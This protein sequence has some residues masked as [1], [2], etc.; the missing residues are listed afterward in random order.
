MSEQV[1]ERP[2]PRGGGFSLSKRY[3][4]LP[5]WAWGLLGGAAVYAVYRFRQSRQA[6]AATAASTAAPASATQPTDFAPQIATLQAEIQ[7]LQQ[8]QSQQAS[9]GTEQEQDITALEAGGREQEQDITALE[10]PRR[11][12]PPKRPPPRRRGAVP[13]PRT[14]PVEHPRPRVRAAARPRRPA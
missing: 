12:P 14:L 2:A 1:P 6:P 13:P 11:P 4:P 3:G 5:A 7:D 10:R 9:A 8:G